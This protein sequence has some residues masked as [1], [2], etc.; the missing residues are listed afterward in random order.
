[1]EIL[2][3]PDV[4]VDENGN[5]VAHGATTVVWSGKIPEDGRDGLG[6]TVGTP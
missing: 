3:S 1:M 4:E 2:S 6:D 5:V